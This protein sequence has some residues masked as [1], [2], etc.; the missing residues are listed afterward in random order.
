MG[1]RELLDQ[2]RAGFLALDVSEA[3]KAAALEHL[4]DW[5]IHDKLEGLGSATPGGYWPLLEWIITNRQFGLLLDSFYQVMPF[6]TGGRRGPVG[7][8]PNRINPYT[9]ASSVQGHVAYLKQRFGEKASLK[10]VV[11]YD[12]GA[13]TTCGG[14]IR[15]TF[16]IHCWAFHQ[17]TSLTWHQPSTAPRASKSICSRTNWKTTSRHL[18]CRSSSGTTAPTGGLNVSASH[19]HPDDNGG[20]FYND[21][22]GQEIPPYDEQMVKI[23]ETISDIESM[24]YG[25]ALASGLVQPGHRGR[26]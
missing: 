2:A 10:V 6:G 7:I 8:G 17:R 24:S 11:A 12:V 4:E 26:P 14:C 18:S 25:D 23:V 1:E 13:T 21:R 19:N 16:P 20:K 15:R 22:G 5:L 3:V 9:M